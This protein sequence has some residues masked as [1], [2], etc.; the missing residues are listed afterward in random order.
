MIGST[1]KI[2]TQRIFSAKFLAKHAVAKAVKIKD[3]KWLAFHKKVWT[4]II[5]TNLRALR[6]QKTTLPE[7]PTLIVLMRIK[8]LP[9]I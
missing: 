2:A 9:K 3:S 8:S 5:S 4:Q 7:R 6:W 1:V